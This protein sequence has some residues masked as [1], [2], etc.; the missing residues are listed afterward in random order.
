MQNQTPYD[1][2]SYLPSTES[3]LLHLD[4]TRVIEKVIGQGATGI[5]IERG[6]YAFKLPHISRYTKIDGVSVEVGSLT[7]KEGDYDERPPLIESIEVEKAI[8]KRQGDPH[9]IV[10]CHNLE[11]TD[12]S[13]QMDLMNGDIR[14]YLAGN[15]PNRKTQLPWL[16]KMAHTMVYVHERRIIIADVRLDNLL[17]DDTLA[18]KFCDFGESTLMPLDWDLDG[19]DELGLSVLTDIGQFGAAMYEVITGLR[20]KF[21]LTQDRKEPEHLYTCPR[22]DSLPSTKNLWLG[23][24]IEKC[25]TQAFKSAKELA[26]EL[27]QERVP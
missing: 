27:D 24:V 22:R 19:T 5:I 13:I 16:T 12:V 11:S 23:H 14:H 6:P 18:L 20:C 26:A 1:G 9:G 2:L 8:Y 3:V 4:G 21:D 7:P 17:L 10:R 15:R 25:W